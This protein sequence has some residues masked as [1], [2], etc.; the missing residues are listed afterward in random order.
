MKLAI[1]VVLYHSEQKLPILLESLKA[2]TFH[3]FEIFFHDNSGTENI[4]FAGGHEKLFHQHDAPFVMLLNDDA[5][6]APDY[7]E[8]VM[9]VIESD[10]N[11]ASITGLVY[12]MDGKTVDTTGLEYKC[13]AQIVDR[14]SLPEAGEVFGVSGA[15]GLYRRS[16][17]EK[18]GGLFDPKWFMYK[19]DVDLA[20]RLREHG[21]ISWFEP[22]AVA[23][24]ARGLKQQSNIFVRLFSEWKRPPLLRRYAYANQLRIYKGHFR[25]SLG[26]YDI[27]RSLCVELL[28]SGGTF[29]MSPWVFFTSWYDLARS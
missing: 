3:D 21:Y 25:W 6:L 17:V 4:G 18:S 20:L 8:Q 13:L 24:H 16:A 10:E 14:Q 11:I 22:K 1:Q 27:L 5:K 28:R 9:K 2:Q 29:I 7:L 19:E 15:V 12:R 26:F 23:W